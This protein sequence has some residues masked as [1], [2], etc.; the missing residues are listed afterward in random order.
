ML[1]SLFGNLLPSDA[2]NRGKNVLKSA[3]ENILDAF[4]AKRTPLFSRRR[5]DETNGV[6]FSIIPAFPRS[7][8]ASH[9]TLPRGD[10]SEAR[11]C[12]AAPCL[13]EIHHGIPHT[14]PRGEEKTVTYRYFVL[15]RH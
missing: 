13:P 15:V 10:F 2:G 6:R 8:T 1:A 9:H 7:T 11:P 12:H 4:C 5:K 14:L 3:F